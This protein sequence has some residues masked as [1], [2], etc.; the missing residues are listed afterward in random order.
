MLQPLVDDE[1]DFVV[2]SRRSGGTQTTDKFRKAG[3]RVFASCLNA[4]VHTKLTD[5]SNGYRAFRVE[6]LDDIAHRLVQDQYQTAE[7]LITAM[8]RGWRITERPTVWHPRASGTTKKGKNRLFGFR[9]G[10]VIGDTWYRVHPGQP[11]PA[12]RNAE[13]TADGRAEPVQYRRSLRRTV[14]D[15]LERRCQ[16][17]GQLVDG[18]A[19]HPARRRCGPA[20]G[21]AGRRSGGCVGVGAGAALGHRQAE[22]PMPTGTTVAPVRAARKATPSLR[23]STTGPVRRSP[24]GNRM[25]TSPASSTCSARRRASRSADSRWTGK[26]PTVGRIRASSPFFHICPWS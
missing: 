1:A 20:A 23:S 24:S 4:I 10:R 15:G 16:L 3:V 19:G 18:A 21:W 6:L 9:Y 26:A 22:P 11:G 5:T 7:L 13:P 2:A 8:Q 25:S 12:R 14:V 17:L